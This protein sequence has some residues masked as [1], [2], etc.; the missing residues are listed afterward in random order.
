M[1]KRI[2]ESEEAEKTF[3]IWGRWMVRSI[4]AAIFIA[5]FVELYTEYVLIPF[6]YA[7]LEEIMETE[8]ILKEYEELRYQ[9]EQTQKFYDTLKKTREKISQ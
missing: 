7:A 5:V 8:R 6:K 2:D 9:N 1:G 3:R 4:F